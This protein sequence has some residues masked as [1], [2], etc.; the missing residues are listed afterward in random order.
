MIPWRVWGVAT[1]K[2]SAGRENSLMNCSD[3]KQIWCPGCDCSVRDLDDAPCPNCGRC[4]FCGQKRSAA[5]LHCS[6]GSIGSVERINE[7]FDEYGIPES[8]VPREL[9]RVRIRKS[10]QVYQQ[11]MSGVTAG[12]F[13]IFGNIYWKFIAAKTFYN[14]ITFLIICGACLVVITNVSQYLL[15]RIEN[16]RVDTEFPT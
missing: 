7:L 14:F 2:A 11:I 15:W 5:V 6:C 13:I 1:S 12:L 9:C 16:D 10:L 4:P 8:E 3:V